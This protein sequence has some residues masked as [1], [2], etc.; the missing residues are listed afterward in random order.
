MF[1]YISY[2]SIFHTEYIAKEDE[3]VRYELSPFF[4]LDSSC[5]LFERPRHLSRGLRVSTDQ[6]GPVN[7]LRKSCETHMLSSTTIFS[8]NRLHPI[9][10]IVKCEISECGI[11]IDGMY[12]LQQIM[13][14]L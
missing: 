6:N 8:P 13:S 10:Q 3:K 4:P 12:V 1:S 7:Y 14:F 2:S 11:V 5:V 9:I